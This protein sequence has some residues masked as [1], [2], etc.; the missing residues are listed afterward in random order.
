M[1]ARS[2]K[3]APHLAVPAQFQAYQRLGPGVKL[4]PVFLI[5]VSIAT[6]LQVPALQHEHI[7]R[8][9]DG[10]ELGRTLILARQEVSFSEPQGRVRTR[11][12]VRVIMQG[13]VAVL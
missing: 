11:N 10:L 9:L 2:K 12:V 7:E 8:L 6:S 1:L 4:V 5:F 3:Q 13:L